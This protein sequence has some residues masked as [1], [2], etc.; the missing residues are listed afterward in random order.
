MKKTVI[1][2]ANKTL[3][4]H[5]NAYQGGYGAH[6]TESKRRNGKKGSKAETRR[7]VREYYG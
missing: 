5:Y 6:G 1:N 2:V 7:L 4:P 3:L